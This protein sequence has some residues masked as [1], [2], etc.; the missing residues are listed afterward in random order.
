MSPDLDKPALMLS[1]YSR[2]SVLVCPSIVHEGRFY[3]YTP[4]TRSLVGSTCCTPTGLVDDAF[5]ANAADGH[6]VDRL[7]VHQLRAH[8]HQERRR[9]GGRQGAH[10]SP[11][12][13]LRP[14]LR[15]PGASDPS[16][17]TVT[18]SQDGQH[19][20]SCNPAPVEKTLHTQLSRYLRFLVRSTGA[21]PVSRAPL[22][23]A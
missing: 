4:V 11:V 14:H 23:F 16:P 10:E 9:R 6:V 3:T 20:L 12:D 1:I 5:N 2:R 13:A 15:R 17:A 8:A 18:R 19:T 21:A 7:L 22:E